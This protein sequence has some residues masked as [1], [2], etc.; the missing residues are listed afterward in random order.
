[1]SSGPLDG[2]RVLDY[3]QYVAGPLA[4]MLLADLGADVVK[5]EPPLGDAYRQ[6]ER[7]AP[8][9]SRYFY[10]LN[11]N[12]R[13]VTLDLKS[14]EDR[15]TNERLI[16]TADA[17]VHNMPPARA[18]AFGL[19]RE[20]VRRVNPG[21]VW[22]NVTAFGSVGPQSGRIGFDMIAQAASG[23]LVRDARPDD[24]VPR[25]SGGIPVA[26]LITGLLAAVSVASSLVARER[27]GHVPGT[28]VSLLGACLAAQIQNFVRVA[29]VD[30][31]VPTRAGSLSRAELS[32]VSRRAST[33]D[34]LEP[35]YRCYEAADGFLVLC[36]LNVPQRLRVLEV[37]GIEDPWHENPQRV[38]ECDEEYRTRAT[39]VPRF[40]TVLKTRD[41]AHWLAIFE[42]AGVPAGDVAV[43]GG[44]FDA[45]QVIANGLVQ[46]VHQPGIGDVDLLGNLFKVDGRAAP[47]TRPAPGLGEH[48]DE[49]LAGLSDS[50]SVN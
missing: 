16:G 5:V 25:R 6:Y 9:E 48:N 50:V 15:W 46:R 13:G 17:V 47:A 29:D 24:D 27:T 21:A 30:E 23:L 14:P 1:V 7:I 18:V 40:S 35:Y 3:A 44:Q 38:P 41:V 34:E 49:V 26:D 43:L 32:E 2:F 8:G 11:R 39:L 28:E 4:T 31:V 42:R 19:D 20:T 22:V 10:A 33:T 37:L 12:K 45:P 36:C